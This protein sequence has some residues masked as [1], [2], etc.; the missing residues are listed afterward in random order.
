MIGF[1]NGKRSAWQRRRVGPAFARGGMI[2]AAHPLTAETGLQVLKAGGNAVDAAVAAG[3]TA[4]VV[5]PEMCGLGGDLFAIVQ[6]PGQAPV[7]VLGSGI[8]PRAATIEQMRAAGDG[9]KMPLNGP[10]SVGVPGM[11][12][13]YG[14]LLERFGTQ[15]FATLATPAIGHAEH[16]FALTVLGAA[17]I[18]AFAALIERFPATAAVLMPDGRAPRAGEVLRQADLARTLKI[19][20]AEG[21]EVFYRGD[22]AGRMAA[23]VQGLGGALSAEDLAGHATMI[24]PTIATTYRGYTLHQTGLPSQ[25]MILLEALNIVENAPAE[26]LAAGD[27]GAIHTLVEAAKLAYADRLGYARDP[28]FG[29]TP[30]DVL[31]SKPWA[32]RRF[33]EI[34]PRRS[35]EETPAG[36]MS[37]GDT[38]YL[39]VVDGD[40]LMVSLI[41]SVSSA[42]GSGIIAGDTGVILN[43]RVGRGFTLE[44]G[45]PNLFAPGKKTMHTLNCWSMRDAD[46]VP[47]MVGGTPGGDGQPQWNLQMLAALIDAGLDVQAATEQPRWSLWPGTDPEHRPNAF[48]LEMETREAPETRAALEALGHRLHPMGGWGAGGAAQVIVRDPATGVL[49]GGSDPRAEGM[50]LGF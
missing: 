21:A 14:A 43:N 10:Q 36:A 32:A 20:A 18:S 1:P 42:F 13:A 39:C 28:A 24:E 29:A 7:A 26:A 17:A 41:Q 27:A 45:H 15:G 35:A 25:G 4:A 37:D 34:D 31:M 48:R 2:A 11:V 5:M 30:L 16:G 9:T 40:G 47:I 33:A 38:T 50:A 22:L 19:I 46:G 23:F 3:L 6:G 12:D 49:A 8:A 44:E